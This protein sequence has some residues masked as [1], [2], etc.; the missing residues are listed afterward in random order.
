[1]VANNTSV[2]PRIIDIVSMADDLETQNQPLMI[3]LLADDPVIKVY[4]KDP[5]NDSV[6]ATTGVRSNNQYNSSSNRN[7]DN[8]NNNNSKKSRRR[9][10]SRK[11]C[12]ESLSNK[13]IQRPPS[14]EAHPLSRP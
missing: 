14:H 11:E 3:P 4:D 2:A 12:I 9:L 1:M 8:N 13:K 10:S 7:D 5:T 6:P